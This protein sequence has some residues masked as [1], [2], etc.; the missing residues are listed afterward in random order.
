MKF[1]K[2]FV[3]AHRGKSLKAIRRKWGMA[4]VGMYWNLAELCAEKL[5][6]EANEEF[7]SEHCVFEFDLSSLSECLGVKSGR[8]EVILKSFQELGQLSYERVDFIFKI[9]MPK[10]LECLD[11][12]ASY[13]RKKREPNA[14]KTRQEKEEE[15]E[16]RR[17][18]NK[19]NSANSQAAAAL[20]SENSECGAIAQFAK[21]KQDLLLSALN[22]VPK[23]LQETWVTRWE[24]EWVLKTLEK[25]VLKTLASGGTL[26]KAWGEIFT[27]WLF[28]E[29]PQSLRKLNNGTWIQPEQ[30]FHEGE[31][32]SEMQKKF[33][34]KSALELMMAVTK[35]KAS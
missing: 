22:T 14:V 18:S 16:I 19:G 33:G 10:L 3:D 4:G 20:F 12:D 32:L 13:T 15:K 8:V 35:Q 17:R 34:A 23:S 25:A 31:T 24:P 5:N 6:K 30:D 7:T 1:F 2:H 28:S 21:T 26:N 9:S 29:R 11:R 27:A